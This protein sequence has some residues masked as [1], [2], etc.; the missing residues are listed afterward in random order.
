MHTH[1][2]ERIAPACALAAQPTRKAFPL[3]ITVNSLAFFNAAPCPASSSWPLQ[4]SPG[5]NWIR[6]FSGIPL[7]FELQ[8]LDFC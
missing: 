8:P 3:D 6:L 4:S 5:F 7:A 1:P 2:L